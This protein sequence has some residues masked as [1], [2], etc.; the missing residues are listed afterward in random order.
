MNV[1][2]AATI[3]KLNSKKF[4]QQNVKEFNNEKQLFTRHLPK[5]Q[6][7]M[8][9]HSRNP[10]FFHDDRLIDSNEN[11]K[12]NKSINNVDLCK[13]QRLNSKKN[14]QV[15]LFYQFFF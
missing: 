9:Y 2:K 15:F 7:H 1:P 6:T 14:D 4:N 10:N 13:Q 5:T 8:A 12:N 11:I 3:Q